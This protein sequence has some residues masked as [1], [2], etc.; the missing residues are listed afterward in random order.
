MWDEMMQMCR[1][2]G[3]RYQDL[4][5]PGMQLFYGTD[6][7]QPGTVIVLWFVSDREMRNMNR[8]Q[9]QSYLSAI[10][11]QFLRNYPIVRTLT[12][13]LT[14]DYVFTRALCGGMDPYQFAYWIVDPVNHAAYSDPA[15]RW[16]PMEWLWPEIS[17]IMTDDKYRCEAGIS[18]SDNYREELWTRHRTMK[19]SEEWV[20]KRK[21]GIF[22]PKI[23]WA[24]IG[25][26]VVIF[27]AS[28]VAG[29]NDTVTW[30][31]TSF[32]YTFE[33]GQIYRLFT[34]FFLHAGIDHILGNMLFLL[35][36]GSTLETYMPK[37]R[38]LSL[39]MISGL[40]ASILSTLWRFIA[41]QPD[42]VGV[43]ASGAIFGLMGA[44]LILLIKRPDVR[45]SSK[46]MPVWAIPAYVLYSLAPA[47]LYKMIGANYNVDV[48]AHLT[49]FFIGL[50]TYVFLTVG[51]K[52][53]EAE[54]KA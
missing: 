5:N 14:D 20:M 50:M 47:I 53:E 45:K 41:D 26:N 7:N 27:I 9:Y 2:H 46:G 28:L 16:N 34:S 13:L 49:G 18:M 31:G 29:L 4:N 24:L 42:I 15:Q 43:G 19:V 22:K 8:M 35:L 39:Y 48:A 37:L 12:L 51:M 6:I 10:R 21:Y 38:Y 33:H 36:F 1:N 32:T 23:T 25:V 40:G 11:G 52:K 54:Q 44:E 30:G 3:L 17:A